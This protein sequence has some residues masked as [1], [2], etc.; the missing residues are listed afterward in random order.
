MKETNTINTNV[1]MEEASDENPFYPTASYCHGYNFYE[2]LM[3]KHSWEELLFLHLRGELPNCKERNIFTILFSSVMNPGPRHVQNRAA[4]SA[5]IGGCP[6]GG[7]LMA[8]MGCSQGD[9]EGG[10][11]VEATMR[12]LSHLSEHSLP[13]DVLS[14]KEQWGGGFQIPG[15]GLLYGQKDDHAPQIIRLIKKYGYPLDHLALFQ[16]LEPVIREETQQHMKSYGVFSAA[17][18]DLGFTPQQGHGL[19]MIASSAGMLT[20]LCERYGEHWSEYPSWFQQG[21]YIYSEEKHG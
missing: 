16:S 7:S 13:A 3:G 12:M 2:N 21:D 8:G 6:P 17:L 20:H 19:Y 1:W 14:M 15:F 10:G 4:M 5:A 9:K 11:A 18:L